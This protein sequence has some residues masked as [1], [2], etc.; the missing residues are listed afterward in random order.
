M[1]SGTWLGKDLKGID[2]GRIEYGSGVLRLFEARLSESK[3][4]LLLECK[5]HG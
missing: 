3:F 2:D 4:S 5:A 1:F